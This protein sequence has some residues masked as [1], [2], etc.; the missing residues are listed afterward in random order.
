[1]M[2]NILISIFFKSFYGVHDY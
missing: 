2:I 1:M